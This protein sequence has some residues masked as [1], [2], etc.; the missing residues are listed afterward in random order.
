MKT[1]Q[2]KIYAYFKRN[3][4]LKVL[5][6]FNDPFLHDDLQGMSWETDYIYVD[7]KGGWFTVK[8]N[9]DHE[10]ADKRVILYMDMPSP[11]KQK[12]L[13]EKFPLMDVLVANMEYCPL[14]YMAFMQQY[15]LPTSMST[16]VEKNLQLLQSTAVMRLLQP[17]YEEG[18]IQKE[19]AMRGLLSSFLHQQRVLEWDA[20]LIHILLLGRG[21][22]QKKRVDFFAKLRTAPLVKEALDGKLTAIFGVTYDDNTS[23]KIA[24]IVQILKYNAIVQNLSPIE[25]DDYK[26]NRINDVVALQQ[27]NRILELALSHSKSAEA[28]M[29]TLQ[30][31]GQDIR[32]EEI[33]RR[34]GAEADYHFIPEQL[35]IP[36]LRKLMEKYLPDEPQKVLNRIE[37]LKLTHNNNGELNTIMDYVTLVARLYEQ[38]A[39]NA[40]TPATPDEYV[41]RYETDYYLI[42][43]LYRVCTETYYKILPTH[44][45]YETAQDVKKTAD[46]SY[47]K[48]CNR[49]NLEWTQCLLDGGGLNALYGLR[50]Q[51]FYSTLIRPIQKKVAV[52]VCDALRYELAKS[53]VQE[54]AKSKHIAKISSALAMLPT[55][56]KFCKPSLLPHKSLTLFGTTDEQNMC[57]DNKLL[58]TTQKRS[59]HLESYREKSVCVP[60]E[61]VAQYNQDKNREVF[62]NSLVYIF[63]DSI[64][65]TGHDGTGKQIVA[66]CTQAIQELST[67]VS[68]ILSSY[69]VTEVYITADHGFI[70]NDMP[71]AEKDKLKVTDEFLEKKSR[72]YLTTSAQP[73][74]HIV[75]Y[76]LGEASGI[77]NSAGMYV[78]VPEG[79][80]R[81]AAPAGGYVFAHGG[82]SLQEMVIPVVTCR[83]ERQDNKQ[84][85]GVMLLDRKLSIIS[86]RLRFKLLQTDAV[87]M[88]MKERTVTI[89]L[90]VNDKPVTAI[91]TLTLDRTDQLLD[92][93]KVSVDLTLNQHVDVKVLQLKVYDIEDGMNP[94]IKENVTNNTLI[95]NDFDFA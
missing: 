53:L 19:I 69:N 46:G 9:L 84:P 22:E 16:F 12:S 51:D 42:D 61:E 34:Y 67:L 47:A 8:Y 40:R 79:T 44:P 20:I 74:P 50:Q 91:Q 32:D 76:P 39:S 35:C 18:T 5:F 55:E 37:T 4:L 89:G 77:D 81:L 59:E 2:D 52:I 54:L 64:D 33:I 94:I 62:K 83:Q 13:Q 90:Y 17:Y 71:M 82:A 85:V 30:E 3:P 49:L 26:V 72:Y 78:A 7:F 70:F 57:V 27:M 87:N 95:E 38:M 80:N 23:D 60:F 73:V 92:A 1:I 43:Q 11:L 29:E 28:F 6:I 25:A 31:L 68:K 14:D 93:R 88:D 41:V 36:I 86:S 65:T 10:W 56:T 24:R 45:L 15:H 66:G 58:D 48:W 21:S 63:H 75:K